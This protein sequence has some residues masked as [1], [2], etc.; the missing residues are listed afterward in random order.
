[1]TRDTAA[2][3]PPS[4]VSSI[5]TL[6]PRSSAAETTSRL[7]ST[8]SSC[9]MSQTRPMILGLAVRSR[10]PARSVRYPCA[11]ASWTTFSRTGAE[12]RSE[13]RRARETVEVD[14]PSACAM[15][16]RVTLATAPTSSAPVSPA[17][18]DQQLQS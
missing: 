16:R 8:W 13:P 6:H 9:P 15:S 3:A 17:V 5:M 10:A 12:I 11:E 18:S 4:A 7:Y 2:A 1:M 14:T